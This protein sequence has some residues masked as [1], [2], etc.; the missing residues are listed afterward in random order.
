MVVLQLR[1]HQLMPGGM[2]MLQLQGGAPK[3]VGCCVTAVADATTGDSSWFGAKTVHS[4]CK[5]TGD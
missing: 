1:L 5:V 4:E 3:L 2:M